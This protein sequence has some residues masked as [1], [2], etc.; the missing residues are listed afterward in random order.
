MDKFHKNK[1]R[2]SSIKPLILISD[3]VIEFR[4]QQIINLTSELLKYKVLVRDL[5]KD[6][7][8][9]SIRNELL[10]IAMFITNNV[11]LYDRFIKEE[12]IPVDAIRI[13]A[14]VDSKYINK[15]RDYIIV[16]TL[17]FGND[18]YKNIQDYL[19]MVETSVDDSKNS[20]VKDIVEYEAGLTVNGIVVWK[21]KK[22]AILLTALGEFKKV[23][24]NEDVLIGQEINANEKKTLKD[25]KIYISILVVFILVFSMAIIYRYNVVTRTI[26]IDTTSTIKLDI[27]GF[28][29][30]LNISSSTEKGAKLIEETNL[31]DQSIDTAIYKIIEYANENKMIK[32]TGIVVTVTGKELKHNSLEKT[33]DFIYRK[34]LKVRFNNSGL[35]HKVN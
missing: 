35:E 15:Y 7:V 9:Y 6:N 14:R 4:N 16:Y 18:K 25:V 22:D 28:N 33:E 32:S 26:V 5:I 34:N 30:V 31:L 21:N 11:E 19:Q 12:D 27:N 8:S 24:L 1:Y 23:K 20:D 3:E 13:A 29:R 2:F 17:I 10:N